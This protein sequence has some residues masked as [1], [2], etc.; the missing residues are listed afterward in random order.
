MQR[1]RAGDAHALAL[2]AGQ[3]VRPAIE[4]L[5]REAHQVDQFAD[6][7]LPFGAAGQPVH[8]ERRLQDLAD[9]LAR[10]Q[11]R[12]R[13][14]E[15][16]LHIARHLAALVGRQ[17][18]DVAPFQAQRAGARLMQA[19][20]RAAQ[21]RLAAARL[22]DDAQHLAGP[23]LHAHAVD[24]AQP[25][26][27]A[28]QQAAPYREIDRQALGLQ[29]RRRHAGPPSGKWQAAAWPSCAPCATPASAGTSTRQ[30]ACTRGQRAW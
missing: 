4:M 7:R 9:A 16:H 15:H 25:R 8:F 23:D 12:E 5:G 6:A 3:L 19:H 22:A 28:P 26:H 21:R 14:L 30:R 13:I 1:E 10:V 18:R 11:R 24:R 2:A 27:L 20:Q 29:Q 17:R